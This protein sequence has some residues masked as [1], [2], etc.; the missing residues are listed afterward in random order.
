MWDICGQKNPGVYLN[1]TNIHWKH[2]VKQQYLGN[3]TKQNIHYSGIFYSCQFIKSYRPFHSFPEEEDLSRRSRQAFQNDTIIISWLFSFR[4]IYPTVQWH[5]FKTYMFVFI[6]SSSSQKLFYQVHNQYRSLYDFQKQD[7][8][9][10][11]HM[12][13]HV[14]LCSI[15][16]IDVPNNGI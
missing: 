12:A 15:G 4:V 9:Q 3:E 2:M 8:S 6:T 13:W 14:I 11:F 10:N 16:Y 1:I 5:T 7:T